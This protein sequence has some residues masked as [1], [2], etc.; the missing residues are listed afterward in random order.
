MIY[1]L[2]NIFS[3][4][5]S[6]ALTI[7]GACNTAKYGHIMWAASLGYFFAHPIVNEILINLYACIFGKLEKH[8]C[9]TK[10]RDHFPIVYSDAYNITAFGLEKLHPF[11]SCKYHRVYQG[12]RQMGIIDSSTKIHEPQIPSRKFLL[13]KM[14]A[15]YLFKLNYSAYIC[16]CLEVPLFFLPAWFLRLRVLNP[17]MRATQGSVDASCL[18]MKHG[19][20]INLAGGYHHATC[21]G[22][23]GFCIYP[24]IT[25]I[26]HFSRKHHGIRKILI[27]DLD[28]HQG[29]G[30]ERDMLQD[31]NVHIIDA[32]NPYIYPGDQ[33]AELAIKTRISVT[34]YDDDT[35]YLNNLEVQIPE[36]YE[37][38]RPELVIYNAGTDCMMN[39]PLGRLNITP[40]GIV[41]RD[42]LMFQMAVERFKVPIVMILSGGYQMTNAPVI[43]DSIQN[44][45]KK[46]DLKRKFLNNLHKDQ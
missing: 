36:V 28:A 31:H 1:T 2:L 42:E 18:A 4:L 23:G 8:N 30:H 43:A 5:G 27:I 40:E 41:Q 6:L 12:L 15:L 21:S 34:S 19:W 32:Y 29:N 20:A 33:Q 25:F 39:D 35:S 14:S 45:V 38:F 3:S 22:G 10:L 46:F 13:E 44:L 16:K 17:M 7:Y 11:D 37:Q 24:D 9:L 26:V